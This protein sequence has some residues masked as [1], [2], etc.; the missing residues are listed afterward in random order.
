METYEYTGSHRPRTSVIQNVLVD[1]E[2]DLD[3]NFPRG[4]PGGCTF[5]ELA[6]YGACKV[7]HEHT[8]PG[9]DNA[10]VAAALLLVALMPAHL[11]RSCHDGTCFPTGAQ[12]YIC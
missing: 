3:N 7:D 1:Y 5:R 10:F 9:G 8:P 2:A 12:T 4:G 11:C 6:L